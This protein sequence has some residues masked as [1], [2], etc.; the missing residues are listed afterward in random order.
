MGIFKREN[1]EVAELKNAV[2][3]LAAELIEQKGY[4]AESGT[5]ELFKQLEQVSFRSAKMV[6]WDNYNR[7]SLFRTYKETAQVRGMVDLIAN[8]VAELAPYI[9][10]LDNQDKE[11]KQFKWLIDLR[12]LS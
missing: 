5:N 6:E 1:K 4:F 2:K 10:I 9:E 11:S 12:H 3:T 7:E 8:A